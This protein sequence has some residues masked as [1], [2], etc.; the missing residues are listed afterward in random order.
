MLIQFTYFGAALCNTVVTNTIY[1]PV[2]TLEDF[3]FKI[4]CEISWMKCNFP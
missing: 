1:Y 3:F 4:H 2:L